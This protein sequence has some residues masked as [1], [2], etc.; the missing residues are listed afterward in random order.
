[1]YILSKTHSTILIIF[2][3]Y[4]PSV[5]SLNIKDL[6]SD[7]LKAV[8]PLRIDFFN[9]V[10]IFENL[11]GYFCR[12][13]FMSLPTSYYSRLGLIIPQ[14]QGITGIFYVYE[15]ASKG[16]MLFLRYESHLSS[17]RINSALRILATISFVRLYQLILIRLWFIFLSIVL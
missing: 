11:P 4:T 9:F 10:S 7:L 12:C 3:N 1:M 17:D 13:A 5:T 8:S 6:R 2:R 14:R 15:V 16:R